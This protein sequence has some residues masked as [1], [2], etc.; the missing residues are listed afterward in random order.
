MT[1]VAILAGGLATRIRPLTEKFPKSLIDINGRP[2]IDYQ[3][4]MLKANGLS[5]VV[6]CVGY[7]GRQIEDHLGDG[8]RHGLK[9]R[10]SYDGRE[11][12][13]TGGALRKALPLLS[14]PFLVIYGDS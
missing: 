9:V 14:D 5:D 11:L 1:S 7:E 2:F 12:V 6:L 3:L 4:Q 8:A 13:G 10:Y